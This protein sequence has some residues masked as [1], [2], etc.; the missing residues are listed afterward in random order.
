[1]FISY[2][3]SIAGMDTT[4][5]SRVCLKASESCRR[6]GESSYTIIPKIEDSPQIEEGE[7]DVESGELTAPFLNGPTDITMLQSFKTHKVTYIWNGHVRT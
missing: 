3:F 7:G 5:P 2:F 4:S 6:R 1:M